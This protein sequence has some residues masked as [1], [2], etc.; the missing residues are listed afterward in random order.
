MR[1]YYGWATCSLILLVVVI[2]VF[3]AW[4]GWTGYIES[5]DQYYASAAVGWM[6][7]FPYIATGHWGL[8]HTIVLPIA[9]S[10]ALGGINETALVLP[11]TLYYL[12][13]VVLTYLA[14]DRLAGPLAAFWAAVLV[15][16]TPLFSLNASIVVTDLTELFLEV[17]SFWSFYAATRR[18]GAPRFLLL[19]GAFAGLA[20]ITRETAIALVAWYGLL[21][22]FGIGMPRK[23]YFWMATSFLAILAVDTIYLWSMTGDFLYRYHVSLRGVAIDNPNHYRGP[24]RRGLIDAPK[25]V[26]PFATLFLDHQFGLLNVLAV[27]AA[28]WLCISRSIDPRSRDVAR[29]LSLLAVVW[30]MILS[31]AFLDVLWSLPRYLS[32]TGYCAAILVALFF[33]KIGLVRMP[34]TAICLLA[35]LIASDLLM[36]Y[37]DDKNLLFGERELVAL[38]EQTTETIYAD[39]AT[40]LSA[41][42]LLKAVGTVDQIK[43]GTPPAG[44]L[45]F[46]NASPRRPAA[47]DGDLDAMKRWEIV[48]E[49]DEE[50]K[51]S[52][53]LLRVVGLAE[54]LPESLRR[55]LDPPPRRAI[56]YR[57]R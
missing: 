43:G 1:G 2:A 32:V 6:T 42:F 12:A 7:K 39:E 57:V 5:D 16:L 30:F 26:K 56:L 46:Y 41:S 22:L 20:W 44:S 21:F 55:K 18:D 33:V 24:T 35:T 37:L 23:R 47:Q 28:I 54:L 15:A 53:K 38:S 10:F 31:Y 29:L 50:S 9:A 40:R 4:L 19:A 49:F 36:T 52:A 45:F 8:R 17:A 14:L 11:T 27:P 51:A 34:R 25:L 48:G 13:L 3:S